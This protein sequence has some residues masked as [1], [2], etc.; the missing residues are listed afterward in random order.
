MYQEIQ[1]EFGDFISTFNESTVF[2]R[3]FETEEYEEDYSH[4]EIREAQNIFMEKVK[5][6]LHENYPGKYI[7]MYGSMGC[8]FVMTIGEAKKKKI[9]NYKNYIVK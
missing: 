8:V 5:K 3:V 7:V 9:R 6:H 4:K 1:E 2:C